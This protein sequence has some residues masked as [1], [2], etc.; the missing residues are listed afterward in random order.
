MGKFVV[1]GLLVYVAFALYFINMAFSFIIIP[2]IVS[3]LNQWF[4]AIGGFLLFAGGINYLRAG[5]NY[6]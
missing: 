6:Y 5:K 4:L 3:N 1:V 2:E